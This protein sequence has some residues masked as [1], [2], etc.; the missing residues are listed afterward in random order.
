ME[1]SKCSVGVLGRGRFGSMVVEYLSRDL[2]VRWHDPRYLEGSTLAETLLSD[3][4]LLC[5]PIRAIR[6]VCRQIA[7]LLRPG[8]LVIDTCSVKVRPIRWLLEELPKSV[9]ILGTHPLFGPDSGKNGIRGLK[10]A[11]C[12]VRGNRIGPIRAYLES[13][14]LQVIETTPDQH[15]REMA[16]TQALFHLISRAIQNTRLDRR[17]I[18]TP[19]PEQFF[20]LLYSLQNDSMELFADLESENPYAAAVRHRLIQA[21]IDLDQEISTMANGE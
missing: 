13:L 18:S 20:E 12:Q 15:D 1:K 14:G 4:V 5:V 7:P 17:Q 8:Q 3:V 6:N 21:L 11:L 19:G 16:E 9:D 10:I 2:P